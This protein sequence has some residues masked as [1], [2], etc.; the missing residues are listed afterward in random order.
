MADE[1]PIL[2]LDLK[3]KSAAE[4]S[5]V[6]TEMEQEIPARSRKQDM[7]L[8]ALKAYVT[9]GRDVIAEGVL[10]VLPDGFGFLRA[11]ESNYV[12]GPDDIYVSPNQIR[13]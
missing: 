8:A 7:I 10:E 13:R 1:T 12:A 11:S 5:A 9:A 6:L 3:Q 4:L 2:L